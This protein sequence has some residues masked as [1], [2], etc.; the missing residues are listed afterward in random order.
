M[1]SDLART[2]LAWQDDH[3]VL[4][5]EAQTWAER[6]KPDHLLLQDRVRAAAAVSHLGQHAD[7]ITGRDDM[8]AEF[9]DQSR[10]LTRKQRRQR[11]RRYAFRVLMVGTVVA[12]IW[13]AIDYL[14][15]PRSN[16]SLTFNVAQNILNR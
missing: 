6:G 5:A 4:L 16:S 1:L 13:T 7:Q 14:S 3:R 9:V 15:T 10:R 11:W 2:D 8:L 12:V